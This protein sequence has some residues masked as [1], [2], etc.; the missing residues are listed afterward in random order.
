[1]ALWKIDLGRSMWSIGYIIPYLGNYAIWNFAIWS[2]PASVVPLGFAI[3]FKKIY[4]PK[5][6]YANENY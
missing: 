5:V 4:D 6:R 3:N 1:M 2:L